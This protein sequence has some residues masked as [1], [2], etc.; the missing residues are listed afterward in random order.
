MKHKIKEIDGFYRIENVYDISL[1]DDLKHTKDD[2]IVCFNC[3]TKVEFYLWKDE[4]SH[5]MICH[6]CGT[7]HTIRFSGRG[8]I[9]EQIY[10]PAK[11][12]KNLITENDKK[13]VTKE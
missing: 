5:H 13:F 8:E 7:I 9:V 11:N 1:E 4:D 6:E 10:I 3:N 2:T 12:I